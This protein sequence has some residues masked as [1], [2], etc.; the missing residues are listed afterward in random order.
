MAGSNCMAWHGMAQRDS[1]AQRGSA[2]QTPAQPGTVWHSPARPVL[3]WHGTA[4][5]V[6]AQMPCS[7]VRG[8]HRAWPEQ[9]G[10][11]LPALCWR[12]LPPRALL[13]SGPPC[14]PPRLPTPSVACLPAPILPQPPRCHTAPCAEATATLGAPP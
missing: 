14:P 5:H 12:L 11:Y 2:W 13:P 4:R 3:G 9:A 7:G 6:S 1:L 8:G 10:P